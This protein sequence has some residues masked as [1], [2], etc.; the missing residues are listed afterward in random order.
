M[1]P[2]IQ[3][4][5]VFVERFPEA[6]PD[7]NRWIVKNRRNSYEPFG[8]TLFDNAPTLREHQA[9][10]AAYRRNREVERRERE[11]ARLNLRYSP[12]HS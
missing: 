6:E 4:Y 9:L 7:L 2:V 12:E 1:S 5:M 10:W 8:S 3:L 11:E